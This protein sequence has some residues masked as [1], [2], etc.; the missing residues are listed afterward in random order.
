MSYLI[1]FKKTNQPACRPQLSIELFFFYLYWQKVVEMWL[2]Q[3]F[4]FPTYII[5]YTLLTWSWSFQSKRHFVLQMYFFKASLNSSCPLSFPAL[6]YTCGQS[7]RPLYAHPKTLQT[8]NIA[9]FRRK[10]ASLHGGAECK[11]HIYG[12]DGLFWIQPLQVAQ[13]LPSS[14]C[15]WSANIVFYCGD[16]TMKSN[17]SSYLNS[18]VAVKLITFC[19]SSY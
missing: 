8:W 13:W 16:N 1:F 2:L 7:S 19:G 3:I 10:L 9:S 18:T 4:T 11:V 17:Q 6:L 12:A 14:R 15:L 5:Y